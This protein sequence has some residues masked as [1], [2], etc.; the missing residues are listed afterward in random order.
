MTDAGCTGP[1]CTYVGPES[2]AEP[3]QC[4]NTAGI[5]ANAEINSIIAQGGADKWFDDDSQSDMLVYNGT[6]WIAYMSD[7]T[8]QAR[9]GLYRSLNFAGTSDWAIDL[10]M[11]TEDDGCPAGTCDQPGVL[12]VAPDVYTEIN[13]VVTCSPPCQL[14]LPPFILPTPTTVTFHPYSTSLEVA[15][16]TTLTTT[17]SDQSTTTITTIARTIVTTTLTIPPVTT[18]EINFWNTAIPN[19]TNVTAIWLTTS[20]LPPPF[21]ITDN[22]D[23]LSQ[24][25]T[26]PPVTRTI[27]PPPWPYS[28]STPTSSSGPPPGEVRRA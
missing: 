18:T 9:V 8:K 19:S 17:D 20:I 14:I 2:A 23:P 28:F 16:T 25:V 26:H 13:P 10:Q 4:T 3:G 21:T 7:D 27:T 24:G 1:M 5:L 11:F 6:Q 12:Y 15:W 22:P